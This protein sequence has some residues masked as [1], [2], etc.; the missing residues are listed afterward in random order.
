MMNYKRPKQ[1]YITPVLG[2]KVMHTNVTISG[3]KPGLNLWN[4]YTK[5]ANL[6]TLPQYKGAYSK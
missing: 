1:D 6:K 5:G 3:T 4:S 2:L